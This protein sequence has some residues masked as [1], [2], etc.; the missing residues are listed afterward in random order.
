MQQSRQFLQ[1]QWHRAMF[2]TITHFI[3]SECAD[4]LHF[5]N[6]LGFLICYPLNPKLGLRENKSD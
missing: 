2:L 3:V 6:S 1:L 5:R 4:I